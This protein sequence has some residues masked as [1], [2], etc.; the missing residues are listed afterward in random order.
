MPIKAVLF[1]LDGTLLDTLDDLADAANRVLA[2][3]GLPIHDRAAYRH[4]VG[5]GSRMLI[6]RALP[7]EHRRTEMIATCLERFK[8]DYGRHWAEATRPYPGIPE[9]L[10][11]LYGRGIPCGVVT[12][13]PHPFACRCVRHY[14]PGGAFGIVLGQ[15]EGLPLKPD[16][17]SALMAAAHLRVAASQCLFLGDSGVDMET[18][19]SA[20]MLPLGAAWGFR[21]RDEL[22]R[23]GAHAVIQHP[24][25]VLAWTDGERRP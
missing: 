14:F 19:R 25:E 7:P 8:A 3:A 22:S 5:D 1:D 6:T 13:K 9:L 4:F 17:R 15:Q 11:S 21:P 10:A 20:G 23:S 24:G 18:A 16:P 12:N 2:G